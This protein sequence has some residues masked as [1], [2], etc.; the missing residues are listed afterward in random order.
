VQLWLAYNHGGGI[1]G[2]RRASLLA[3]RQVQPEASPA[4]R[5]AAPISST[6][7]PRWSEASTANTL[8]DGTSVRPSWNGAPLSRDKL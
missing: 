1:T 3:D 2:L 6:A 8:P 4:H 5:S 7:T